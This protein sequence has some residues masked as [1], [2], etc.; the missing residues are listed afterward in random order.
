[1]QLRI[2]NCPDN[3][4]K[5]YIQEAALFF[6]N[7]LVANKRVLK[8]C[9]TTIRFNAKMDNYG[10]ASVEEFNTKNQPREFLI[11]L[12]PGIGV[13][14]ILSTL[15]HEMV[16]VKQYIMGELNDDMSLWK[17]KKV[18]SDKM[19]Y[20]LHPWE[21]EAHG[22]EPGLLYKFITI[23]HLWDVFD[24]FK[25]PATPIVSTPIRWK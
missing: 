9:S 1:M 18:D 6:A 23:N 13:R 4:F 12:H 21:I 17:G 15:A 2:V 22:K 16:H 7:E 5:P 25:N 14:N 3:N 19:D 24:E 8:N 10:F 11:E 20:W